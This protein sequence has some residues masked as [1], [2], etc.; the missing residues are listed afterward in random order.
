MCNN[1]TVW[2]IPLKFTVNMKKFST[3]T[4]M[5]K[6]QFL[7]DV[8]LPFHFYAEIFVIYKFGWR[9]SQGCMQCLKWEYNVNLLL[10]RCIKS[11]N[12]PSNSQQ[13]VFAYAC[14]NALFSR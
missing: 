11:L 10:I 6:W 2:N 14:F 3:S 13:N 12:S 1:S 8:V 4:S 5:G 9:P 7:S